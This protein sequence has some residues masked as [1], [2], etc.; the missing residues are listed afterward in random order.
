MVTYNFL[1]YCRWFDLDTSHAWSRSMRARSIRRRMRRRRQ[2]RRRRQLPNHDSPISNL[3][4][5]QQRGLTNKYSKPQQHPPP[6]ELQQ[7]LRIRHLSRNTRPRLP[8]R[9]HPPRHAPTS[10][11]PIAIRERLTQHGRSKLPPTPYDRSPTT[12]TQ[13]RSPRPRHSTSTHLESLK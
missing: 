1:Y 9:P 3:H 13:P 7:R 4:T 5:R 6:H 11:R 2:G 10:R 8:Q 12:T